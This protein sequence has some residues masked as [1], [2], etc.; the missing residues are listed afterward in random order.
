[1]LQNLSPRGTI[2][3]ISHEGIVLRRY[4]DAVNV[5]T[6][7]IGHTKMAGAPDPKQF[8]SDASIEYVLQVYLRDME[9]YMKPV[10][11]LCAKHGGC[12]PH[13]FDALTSFTFNLG[14][15]NLASLTKSRSKA[16]WG[17]GM[18]L[19]NKGRVGGVLKVL[20][21]LV[22]RRAQE[23]ALF[24]RGEYK[25]KDGRVSMFPVNSRERPDY[26]RGKLVDIRP[27]LEQR[28]SEALPQPVDPAPAAPKVPS[29]PA[30]VVAYLMYGMPLAFWNLSTGMDDLGRKLVGVG[31]KL[32]G[33]FKYGQYQEII[34]AIQRLPADHEVA[35][36]GHSY[37]GNYATII[38]DAVYPRV[39]RY[40]GAYD[41]TTFDTRFGYSVKPLR[42]N[43]KLVHNFRGLQRVIGGRRLELAPG[44]TMTN[45]RDIPTTVPHGDVDTTER[46][47]VMSVDALDGKE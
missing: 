5:W 15:G 16:N 13:E 11:A 42:D 39:V 30:P 21:G 17:K 18:L 20:D 27:Y 33:V 38:A 31:V 8:T 46:F 6:F 41:P 3:L 25:V 28:G 19:Y 1:M 4:L 12:A 24:E 14:E 10:R 44:N 40:L 34:D 7:G 9:R 45:Y 22:T 23:R 36:I 37:G 26:S 29:K 43:V 35:L 32:G 2:D 47:H